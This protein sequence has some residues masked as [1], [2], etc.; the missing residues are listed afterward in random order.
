MTR[1]RMRKFPVTRR[2]VASSGIAAALLVAA[3]VGAAIA[4]DDESVGSEIMTSSDVEPSD[5]ASPPT[6][7]EGEAQDDELDAAPSNHDA[8]SSSPGAT[9]SESP[10]DVDGASTDPITP[11]TDEEIFPASEPSPSLKP[12]PF[13]A[14]SPPTF[15]PSESPSSEEVEND[16]PASSE[17]PIDSPASD[18]TH[19]AETFLL[20]TK[21]PAFAVSVSAASATAG[22]VPVMKDAAGWPALDEGG[23]RFYNLVDDGG[24]EGF[25]LFNQSVLAL[26]VLNRRARDG[27]HQLVTVFKTGEN[28]SLATN[29]VTAGAPGKRAWNNV[30]DTLTPYPVGIAQPLERASIAVEPGTVNAYANSK[31]SAGLAA[32]PATPSG[33]GSTKQATY[34]SS[35]STAAPKAVAAIPVGDLPRSVAITP[36]GERVYVSNYSSSTV[37]VIDTATNVVVAEIPVRSPLTVAI[38]ADGTRAYVAGS[39]SVSEI[40]TATNTVVGDVPLAAGPTSLAVSPNGDRL[41][42]AQYW[43]DNISI[44]DTGTN[45]VIAETYVGHGASAVAISPDGSRVYVTRQLEQSV[46]DT[47][48]VIDTATNSVIAT[49]PVPN[50]PNA[51]VVSPNGDRVYISAG[52]RTGYDEG[53]SVSVIDSAANSTIAT[54][55]VEANAYGLA[56]NKDGRLLFVTSAV[57]DTVTVID[58]ATNEMVGDPIS[59]RIDQDLIDSPYAIAISPD[60]GR[61]YTA[62]YYRGTVSVIDTDG[63]TTDGSAGGGSTDGGSSGG[64]GTGPIP[65]FQSAS[66]LITGL[67]SVFTSTD[68]HKLVDNLGFF[69]GVLGLKGVA[70][71]TNAISSFLFG[72]KQDYAGL[73]LHATQELGEV[74]M[75]AAAKSRNPVLYLAG[76]AVNSWAYA[77]TL[78]VETDWSNPGETFSYAISHPAETAVETG[79]AAVTVLGRI[80]GTVISSL[81]GLVGLPR[82]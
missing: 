42:V 29:L 34:A 56:I 41:Y 64:D 54:I 79:K 38:T 22:D 14:P 36:D 78:A 59:V 5:G 73:S 1:S 33:T 50:N 28:H 52:F 3:P 48:S 35:A 74:V 23:S 70:N 8:V 53:S 20:S 39:T 43:S 27:E 82:R 31:E 45:T 62:N 11:S 32:F 55:P 80:A 58:T 61:L 30:A 12:E 17:T 68:Y 15:V 10:G 71:A 75:A 63:I 81:G 37:S 4:D 46:T 72:Y 47:V 24:A 7:P 2:V 40:D 26:G 51:V 16:G 6:A 49:I 66:K 18:S 13:E 57:A 44:I 9:P 76:A 60:G 19:P 65:T 69:A 21:T 67:N 77:A 25:I